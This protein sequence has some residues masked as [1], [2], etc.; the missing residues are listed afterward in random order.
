ML[1][2]EVRATPAPRKWG[3]EN[4]YMIINNSVPPEPEGL[5]SRSQVLAIGP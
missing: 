3:T 4:V 1:T 5:S 2:Y